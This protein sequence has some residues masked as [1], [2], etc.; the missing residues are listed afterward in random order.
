MTNQFENESYNETNRKLIHI[1]NGFWAFLIPFFPR[2][3]ALFITVVAFIFVFVLSRPNSRFGSLFKRSF[4]LMAREED[5][6][7]GYLHGP[8]IYVVMV[9][10]CIIFLDY[11]LAGSIFAILAF[12]DGFA[13]LIGK[14]FGNH[15]ISNEKTLEGSLAFFVF[16]LPTSLFV[17]LLISVFN[18]P[19]GG[20][21]LIFLILLPENSQFIPLEILIIIFV[22]V[23][24]TITIVELFFSNKI[25]DNIL[26]PVTG[27]ILFYFSFTMAI[28]IF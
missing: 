21:V 13:T 11:R 10:I 15:I 8:T 19:T 12:G 26:I 4:Q 27:I 6:K 17:F 22:F 20:F 24:L 9:I 28:M 18:T 25:N 2:L 7:R 3:L 1:V 5:W 14:K 16:A 23:N